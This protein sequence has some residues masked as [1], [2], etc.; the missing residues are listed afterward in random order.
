MILTAS[1]RRL[2]RRRQRL[3]RRW[4]RQRQNLKRRAAVSSR[5]ERIYWRTMARAL[6]RQW[7]RCRH[8]LPDAT[9]KTALEWWKERLKRRDYIALLRFYLVLLPLTFP[10]CRD[11]CDRILRP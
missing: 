5:R 3:Q 6:K 2:Q 4:R 11:E 9:R 1:E 7:R 10:R 8:A